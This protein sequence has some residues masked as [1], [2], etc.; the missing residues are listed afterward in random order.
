[1]KLV[2]PVLEVPCGSPCRR[3]IYPPVALRGADAWIPV[4]RPILDLRTDDNRLTEDT[5][6]GDDH[7]RRRRLHT[8]S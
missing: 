7:L 6:S 4:V 3:P 2:L 8:T 1:M 5:A